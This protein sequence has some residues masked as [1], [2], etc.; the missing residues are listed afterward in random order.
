MN[1]NDIWVLFILLAAIS[2]KLTL[3]YSKLDKL[4]DN[5]ERLIQMIKDV[6]LYHKEIEDAEN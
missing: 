5:A 4:N 2:I 6:Y 1:D 3:I